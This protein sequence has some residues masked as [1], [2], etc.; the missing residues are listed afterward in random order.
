MKTDEARVA[1]LRDSERRTVHLTALLVVLANI[2]IR[3]AAG[4][5]PQPQRENFLQNL[6]GASTWLTLMLGAVLSV[7]ARTRV[8]AQ[9]IFRGGIVVLLA[10][11]V[12][13]PLV[14]VV[15]G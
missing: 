9:G 8:V 4:E 6:A 5:P 2:G 10:P 11:L 12:V 3:L 14:L 7:P 15:F 13:L 1:A